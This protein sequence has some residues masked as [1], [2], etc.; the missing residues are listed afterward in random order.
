MSLSLLSLEI[1]LL[2][3]HVYNKC[4]EGVFDDVLKSDDRNFCR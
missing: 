1:L 4:D 3:V 2:N